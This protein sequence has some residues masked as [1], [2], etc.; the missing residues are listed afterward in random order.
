[1][2]INQLVSLLENN[3]NLIFDVFDLKSGDRI[4]TKVSIYEDHRIKNTHDFL[5]NL[6]NSYGEIQVQIKERKGSST[7]KPR[8]GIN[9]TK[10]KS[11]TYNNAP[12]VP[13]YQQ[14]NDMIPQGLNGGLNQAILTDMVNARSLGTKCE[15]LEKNNKTL[16]QLNANL[17]SQLRVIKEE[18]SG[19]KV[20]HDTIETLKNL[21]LKEALLNQK[22]AFS[23][24]AEKIDPNILLPILAN[25]AKQQSTQPTAQGLSEV[26]ISEEKQ[27][28]IEI[29]K[30]ERI[31]PYQASVLIEIAVKMTKD[32]SISE[33]LLDFI[34]S[35]QQETYSDA[36][37]IHE[38]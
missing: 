20:K 25:L 14:Q 29:I 2:T 24:L 1:M 27:E 15:M 31:L 19:L 36:E 17:E 9:L 7:Q 34:N 38:S 30:N 35:S 26:D 3:S 11:P 6:I 4:E 33:A 12:S 16:E 32:P 5:N 23:Q 13:E 22:S 37:I 10:A 21:E 28:L 18:F 8:A